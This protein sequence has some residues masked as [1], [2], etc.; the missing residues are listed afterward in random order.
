VY[1][2]K[3]NKINLSCPSKPL[4]NSPISLSIIYGDERKDSNVAAKLASTKKEK[5]KKKNSSRRLRA[6]PG[7]YKR[8]SVSTHGGNTG[9]N[10]FL[11]P[12][13]SLLGDPIS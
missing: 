10:M 6:C 3:E 5:P 9:D 7:I 1:K 12:R 11:S 13:K 8:N 2:I 4:P